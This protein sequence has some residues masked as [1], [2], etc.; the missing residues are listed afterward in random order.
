MTTP[1][2][3]AVLDALASVRDP[4]LDESI[5]ELGFVTDVEVVEGDVRVLLRLPTYFCAP[6]FAYLM[7]ADAKAAVAEVPGAVNVFVELADHFA[8]LEISDAVACGHSFGET[9]AGQATGELDELRILFERKAFVSRQADVCEE[10]LAAGRSPAELLSMTV[11]DLPGGPKTLRYVEQ[12]ER[13]GLDASPGAWAIV[14]ADGTRVSSDQIEFYLRLARLTRVSIEGN[15]AFCR[16]LLQT[17]Y[18]V[19][20]RDEVLV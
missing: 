3:Q 5:T 9:F 15:A 4:E 11:A 14:R 19:E 17:R 13:L 8:G 16:G 2:K 12:L 10:L 6:N 18:A 20:E 7:V 1:T